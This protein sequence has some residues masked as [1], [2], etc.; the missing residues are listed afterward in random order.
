V[1]SRIEIGSGLPRENSGKI[2]KRRLRDP[3][4]KGAGRR[5]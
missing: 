1:P 2:F 3:D 5:F 4:W